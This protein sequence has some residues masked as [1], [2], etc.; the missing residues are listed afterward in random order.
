MF[1]AVRFHHLA[2]IPCIVFLPLFLYFSVS[3]S[4]S[5]EA[6]AWRRQSFPPCVSFEGGASALPHERFPSEGEFSHLSLWTGRFFPF[7]LLLFL[8]LLVKCRA[9]KNKD[10]YYLCVYMHTRYQYR[11]KHRKIALKRLQHLLECPSKFQVF[12]RTK[13]SL[14]KIYIYIYQ[15]GETIRN[16]HGFPF[17][18]EELLLCV[19]A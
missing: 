9:F 19:T 13:Y 7:P 15:P 16:H 18:V 12:K 5:S 8:L 3:F 4:A 6:G 17:S 2:V 10:M 11:H 1:M 14:K